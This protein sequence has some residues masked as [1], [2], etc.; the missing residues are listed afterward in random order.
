MRNEMSATLREKIAKLGP[1]R[2]PG[3]A[4][5]V[6]RYFASG[7]LD[8]PAQRSSAAENPEASDQCVN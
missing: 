2:L 4:D 8:F 6:R 1:V 3:V 7:K 5:A